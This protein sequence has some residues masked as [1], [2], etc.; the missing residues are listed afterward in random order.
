VRVAVTERDDA[1]RAVLAAVAPGTGLRDGL[2]RILR[3]NTGA[4]IVLGYNEV[5]ESLCTG[6]FPLDVVFAATQLR[7]LA[8]MDGAVVLTTDGTGIVRAATHL[9]PDSTIFTEESGTRHRTAQ[10]VSS[11]TGFPVISVSQSMKIISL[12]V[13]GRRYVLEDTAALLSRANQAVST[14]ERYKF[15]LDEVSSTLSALEI[16]DLVTVRDAG[17]VCQRLEMVRRIA[18]EIAGYVVELG[19]DGRLLA[20][21]LEE[22]IA[23]VDR[24]R[25]LIVR[26]YL[27]NNRRGRTAEQAFEDLAQMS[28][29]E[30]LD[31]SDIARALGYPGSPETLDL[32]VSPRGYRLMSRV[33]RLPPT[34][35][36]RVV[37]HFGGLQ[38]VLAATIEEL[39]NVDGVGEARARSIREGLSRLAD[40][41]IV[42]RYS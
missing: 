13:G 14:L 29:T 8:K 27:P 30:L 16:E 18:D 21:Q 39:Q 15:R 10:R 1:L 12:Y 20:L 36:T 31:V 42:E 9:M 41:S 33:P 32:S 3:G 26:D 11:Q 4:L 19:T 17:M 25:E 22:L 5:V 23:G 2:D 28:P 38:K 34:V 35:I 40:A 7:E 24:D 6:G 37:E